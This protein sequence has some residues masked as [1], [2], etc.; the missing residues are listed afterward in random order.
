MALRK[1]SMAA[2][3]VI[4]I[5]AAGGAAWWALSGGSVTVRIPQAQ[6]QSA[7][8][9]KLPIEKSKGPL[10]YSVAAAT[11]DLRP[12]GRI[13]VDVEVKAEIAKRSLVARMAGSGAL[14]YTPEDHSFR[15]SQFIPEKIALV[16]DETGTDDRRL[17]GMLGK[18]AEAALERA[19][20]D[21][22]SL[23]DFMAGNKDA[24]LAKMRDTAA[25]LVNMALAKHPVF[26]LDPDKAKGAKAKAGVEAARLLLKSVKTEG[27]E[28]VVTLAP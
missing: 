23:K 7:I 12:D 21:D 3:A 19:G 11:V 20:V 26:V 24:A 18:K 8:D 16:R 25:D 28:L 1:T 14:A 5:L 6:I 13:G 9:K 22:E 4:L 15:V 17:L 10:R 27:G 2:A